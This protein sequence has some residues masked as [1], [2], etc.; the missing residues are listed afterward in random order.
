MNEQ[1]EQPKKE[2]GRER[3]KRLGIQAA[4]TITLLPEYIDWGEEYGR[5]LI[6][7]HTFSDIVEIALHKLRLKVEGDSKNE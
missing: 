2:T 1:N 7:I 4:T 3:A 5:T 6:P